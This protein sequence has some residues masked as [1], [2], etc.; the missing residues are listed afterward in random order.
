MFFGMMK[1]TMGAMRKLQLVAVSDIGWF[2]ARALESPESYKGRKIAIAGEELVSAKSLLSTSE[3]PARRRWSHR[4]P[5][6]RRGSCCRRIC[7]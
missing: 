1:A 2:A 4:F 7:T 6:L 5:T 3:S